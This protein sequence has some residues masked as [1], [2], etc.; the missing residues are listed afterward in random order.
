MK[1]DFE[2]IQKDNNYSQLTKFREL[3]FHI[4][5]HV[6]DLDSRNKLLEEEINNIKDI[7]EKKILKQLIKI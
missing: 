2:K 6:H 3:E 1:K 5:N 7:E 4:Q